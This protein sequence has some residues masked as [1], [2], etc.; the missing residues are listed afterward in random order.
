MRTSAK[1][2]SRPV[3]T[4]HHAGVRGGRRDVDRAQACVRVGAPHE[5]H[6]QQARQLDVTDVAAAAGEQARILAP[7]HRGTKGG[8]GTGNTVRARHQGRA[9]EGLTDFVNSR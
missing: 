8:I 7:A 6:V 1:R 9:R 2:A 4:A 3:T 5:G